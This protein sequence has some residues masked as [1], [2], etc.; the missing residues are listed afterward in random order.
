MN[1]IVSQS[2]TTIGTYADGNKVFRDTRNG[3]H[4]VLCQISCGKPDL[5]QHG[6]RQ[7]GAAQQLECIERGKVLVMPEGYAVRVAAASWFLA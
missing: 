7:L 1:L 5:D 6:G 2:A 3:P 4:W